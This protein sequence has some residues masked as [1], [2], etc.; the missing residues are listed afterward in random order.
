MER[1][2]KYL[3]NKMF[4]PTRTKSQELIKNSCC[5]VNG[6]MINKCN[7]LVSEEDVIEVK[8]ETIL[9][10]VSRGG[11]KLEYAIKSFNYDLSNKRMM[12][13]GSSTGGF[14]DCALQNGVK[15]IVAIDVGTNVMHDRL[16]SNPKI[17]L[18]EQTNIKDLND[19]YFNNIDVITVDVSFISLIKIIEIVC[20]KNIKVDMLVL[21]KPQFE[22]GKEIALKYKGIILNKDVHINILTKVIESF[23]HYSFYLK[24]IG[25]SP[26]K[27]GDGNIE[28]VAFITNKD[29]KNNNFNINK[30]VNKAF[31]NKK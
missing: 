26:I 8:D 16:R 10:Y 30:L 6:K 1:L 25:V 18:H 9:K 29:N 31:D 20:S 28:Y 4:A 24:G 14:S 23:N 3:V 11:L 2:D 21:I 13:I 27:G 22:C 19:S 7:Y 5:F 17:D 12:D 15:S